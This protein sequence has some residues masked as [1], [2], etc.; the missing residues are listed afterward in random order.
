MVVKRT[1]TN[2]KPFSKITENNRKKT[3]KNFAIGAAATAST[4]AGVYALINRNKT[5]LPVQQQNPNT[6]VVGGLDYYKKE[7][8]FKNQELTKFHKIIL[9]REDLIEKIE[10]FYKNEIAKKNIELVKFH[11]IIVDRENLI[12][13]LQIKK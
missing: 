3:L 11:N 6:Y 5:T 12:K 10:K 1:H 2:L 13:Q 4:L 8:D 9:D 7:L